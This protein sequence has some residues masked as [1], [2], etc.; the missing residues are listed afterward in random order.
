MERRWQIDVPDPNDLTT[1]CSIPTTTR[2]P[3]LFFLSSVHLQT[4]HT[5]TPLS[6]ASLNA[7]LDNSQ[8][9]WGR[10]TWMKYDWWMNECKV[11]VQVHICT[12]T[13]PKLT[14]CTLIV[15][16]RL[17]KAHLVKGA[18]IVLGRFYWTFIKNTNDAQWTDMLCS[19]S[20]VD[21]IISN[22]VTLSIHG[23]QPMDLSVTQRLLHPGLDP[24]MLAP[25]PPLFL[26]PLNSQHC[27]QFSP[28]HVQVRTNQ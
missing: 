11:Q 17:C 25:R 13:Y 12:H 19:S 15:Y 6:F 21:A 22:P 20:A 24:A 18:Q 2:F 14:E 5:E 10:K 3:S 27:S 16:D 8:F 1:Q 4:Q 26:G 7:W 9:I 28:R 23:E